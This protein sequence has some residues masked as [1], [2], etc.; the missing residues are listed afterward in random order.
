M[1]SAPCGATW[2]HA[3]V[4]PERCAVSRVGTTVCGRFEALMLVC[5][6]PSLTGSPADARALGRAIA[7]ACALGLEVALLSDVS[8]EVIDTQLR[9]RPRGIGALH[10]MLGGEV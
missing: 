5:R 2:R 4:L 10:V 9:A 7:G 8:V 3:C 6:G 1:P